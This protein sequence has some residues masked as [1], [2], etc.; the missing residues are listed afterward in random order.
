MAQIASKR[1]E[2]EEISQQMTSESKTRSELEK[3]HLD[4]QHQLDRLRA[5]FEMKSKKKQDLSHSLQRLENQKKDKAKAFGDNVPQLIELLKKNEGKFKQM[6]LGPVG[7]FQ[8][9]FNGLKRRTFI[10]SE[11]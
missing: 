4:F 10:E 1:Q 6:P 8:R 11:E 5:E 7:K 3:S 2:I 9:K